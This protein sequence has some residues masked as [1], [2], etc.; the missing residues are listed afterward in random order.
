MSS[1]S[2]PKDETG[3]LIYSLAKFYAQYHTVSDY[4]YSWADPLT[5]T[6]WTRVTFMLK[7]NLD[8]RIFLNNVKE[9]TH[10]HPTHQGNNLPLNSAKVVNLAS[11]LSSYQWW[12]VENI[13]LSDLSLWIDITSDGSWDDWAAN[14]PNVLGN[15]LL[16]IDCS[17]SILTIRVIVLLKILFC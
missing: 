14:L 8:T 15:V 1:G 3:F 12:S 4:C 5:S 7:D 10:A 16:L 11:S 9:S 2:D 17:L 13:Q 6:E